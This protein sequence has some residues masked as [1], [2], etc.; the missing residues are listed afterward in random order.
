MENNFLSV[1]MVSLFN[2]VVTEAVSNMDFFKDT[3]NPD[4]ARDGGKQ[5]PLRFVA[6][7]LDFVE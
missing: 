5:W 7:R 4:G 6:I 2:V 3:G 1:F